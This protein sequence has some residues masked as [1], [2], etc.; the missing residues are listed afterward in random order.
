LAVLRL[1]I[2]RNPILAAL[3]YGSIAFPGERR[4]EIALLHLTRRGR[5]N[6]PQEMRERPPHSSSNGGKSLFFI[7]GNVYN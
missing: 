3:E 7:A 4:G 5:E 6:P 1:R 2:Y